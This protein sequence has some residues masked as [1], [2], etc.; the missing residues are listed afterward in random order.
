[1]AF[2]IK[3][4]F[5]VPRANS[6]VCLFLH[7]FKDYCIYLACVLWVT[8]IWQALCNGRRYRYKWHMENFLK[9]KK[10]LKKKEGKKKKIPKERGRDE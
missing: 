7:A 10:K 5:K 8:T 3:A 2:P 4:C 6:T 9:I 1:M